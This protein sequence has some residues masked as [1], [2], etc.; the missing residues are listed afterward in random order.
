MSAPLPSPCT[1]DV[2]L[3]WGVSIPMRDG[4][5]LN[6]T[7]Y[8]PRKRRDPSPALFTMTP[9]VAQVY[10]DSGMYFAANGYPFLTIDVRGRGNSQG[11]FRP[12]INE[13]H[14]A[15]DIVEWLA[16]QEYC[17]GQV[18]MWGGSYGGYVQ[19]AAARERPA[20]LAA[21]APTAAPRMGVDF[22]GR[23]NLRSP[24]LMQWLT[25]VWGRTSQDK[26]FWGKADEWGRRFQNWSVSGEPFA[27]LDT[28]LGSP[29]TVFQEWLEHPHADDYW[30]SYGLSPAQYAA[31]DFP[32]LTVTGS[33]DG[34]QLG[35]LA[36]YR[37]H[38]SGNPKA[39]HHLVIG[40]WD[41]A[42]TRAP[43]LAF[44]GITA[45]EASL[46]DVNALHLSW[47]NWVLK[48]GPKPAFLHKPVAYYVMGADI[49]RHADSLDAITGH[50]EALYLRSSGNPTDLFTSG[51]LSDAPTDT[52]EPDSYIYD[53]RDVSLAPLE[54][55]I[56]PD[57][58]LG[59]Q[60]LLHASI[61][62]QL[63]YHSLPFETDVEISG[64]FKL[65]AWIA[66]DRPDTDFRASVYEVGLDGSSILLSF[67]V[68]RARYRKSLREEVLIE[69][70]EPLR[71]DF[72]GFM[73][74]SRMVKKAHRLRLVI[75]PVN[76]IY[77][78]KNP[79]TGAP[80]A[81]SSTDGALPVTV[82]LFHDAAHPSALHI[83]IATP[84][85]S[86]ESFDP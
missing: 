35:A 59:D 68:L 60:Q 12:L 49:W 80:V 31:V 86:A 10:H 41:H 50:S 13:A 22:P 84:I 24:Y 28:Q 4:V 42:G 5:L 71:Y 75:G 27:Q 83:P 77:Y 52:G 15:H 33:Y 17:N 47:Y 2:L 85:I 39:R 44:G 53:P 82:K 37:D 18:A 56:D 29:S 23:G 51:S 8:L 45:G 58:S 6:A 48:G 79:N 74:I 64:F 26:L 25:L 36:H 7:L 72:D 9:Y 70:Q 30:E 57:E 46:L 67:D 73:F 14:D 32:A 61:G 21:I 69:T 20:H 38:L 66:I 63:I 65:T 78:E 81:Q 40:P 43:Q 62:K 16:A 1:N 11:T 76:S 34:N 54:A 3:H 55:T 19:W